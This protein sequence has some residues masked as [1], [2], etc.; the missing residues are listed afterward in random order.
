MSTITVHMFT[1]RSVMI[2]CGA[3]F[4]VFYRQFPQ[5]WRSIIVQHSVLPNDS[6]NNAI[7][8]YYH[9]ATLRVKQL[10]PY[11]I[12]HWPLMSLLAAN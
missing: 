7:P 4:Y 5:S 9:T 2:H 1:L 6:C 11:Q 12:F 10:F 8:G 3:P